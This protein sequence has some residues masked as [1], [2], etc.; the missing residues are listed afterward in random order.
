MRGW[1]PPLDPAARKYS[2]CHLTQA[3]SLASEHGAEF[4]QGSDLAE[5]VEGAH[6]VYGRSWSSL[7]DYGNATLSATRRARSG[8]WTVDET[9]M[10]RGDEARL[11]HAMPVRRNLEDVF[12][13]LTR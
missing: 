9:L 11:M 5:A 4:S 6:V 7:E 12:M 3:R 10:A 2:C 8:G 13:E 1:L